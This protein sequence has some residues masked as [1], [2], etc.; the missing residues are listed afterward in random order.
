[1]T[2]RPGKIW[3]YC[4]VAYLFG[5]GVLFVA[6]LLLK[7]ISL[8]NA[9]VLADALMSAPDP[10]AGFLTRFQATLVAVG[11]ET[12]VLA[13]LCMRCPRTAKLFVVASIAGFF[14]AYHVAVRILENGPTN[15][16]PCLGDAALIGRLFFVKPETL[17]LGA[18]GFLL[19]GAYACL[20][21]ELRVR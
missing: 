13:Y 16:C 8:L 18:I 2:K 15:A 3:S 19:I 21:N 5:A 12:G 14:A 10:I 11:L 17:T 4:S 6:T 9:E 7:V 20:F 1:M